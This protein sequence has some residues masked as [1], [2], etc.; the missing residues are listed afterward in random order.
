MNFV[1]ALTGETALFTPIREANVIWK[2]HTPNLRNLAGGSRKFHD[3]IF[4]RFADWCDEEQ[5]KHVEQVASGIAP[6]QTELML[7]V[8]HVNPAVV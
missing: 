2:A 3:T 7:D 6:K 1:T 5:I 4:D 8:D